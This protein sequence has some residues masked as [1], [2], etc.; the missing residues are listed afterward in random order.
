MTDDRLTFAEQAIARG[1]QQG[2]ITNSQ[3]APTPLSRIADP[4]WDPNPTPDQNKDELVVPRFDNHPCPPAARFL[5]VMARRAPVA[6]PWRVRIRIGLA[7]TYTMTVVSQA[8]APHASIV[9]TNHGKS[10]APMWYPALPNDIEY[11]NRD[12]LLPAAPSGQPLWL[13]DD[14]DRSRPVPTITRL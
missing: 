12:Q 9:T 4:N 7:A 8:L 1:A 13:P 2:A 11:D 14:V 5:W 3:M 6:P 10:P